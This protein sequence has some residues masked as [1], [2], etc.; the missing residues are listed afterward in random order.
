MQ[1]SDMTVQHLPAPSRASQRELSRVAGSLA[2]VACATGALVFATS[3]S[4]TMIKASFER[5]LASMPQQAGSQV[6]Q[7]AQFSARS[8]DE[9]LRDASI[10]GIIKTAAVGETIRLS[11]VGPDR[12]LKIVDVRDAGEA[13]THIDTTA[14]RARVLLV[15]CRD[16]DE[17][18]GTEFRLR[19]EGGFLRD[20]AISQ[21]ASAL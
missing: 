17:A 4:D 3:S 8:E 1:T 5:A 10:P 13:A 9:W 16:G 20:V 6:A 15:T 19:L 11:G 12:T 7:A 21:R 2:L 14:N 18:T